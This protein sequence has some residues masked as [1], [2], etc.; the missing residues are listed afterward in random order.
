MLENFLWV[1]KYRPHTI[2]DVILPESLKNTFQKFVDQ[3]QIPN[4]I[5]SG[6]SGIGKTTI[7][8]AL[9]DE[10]GADYIIINASM[11]SGIDTLRTEILNYVTSLSLTGERKFVILDEA[12]YLNPNSTQPA[13]RNFIETYSK[14]AGFIF[15]CNYKNKL[16]PALHSRCAVIDFKISKQ[17]MGKLAVQFMKRVEHI[18]NTENIEFEKPAV[19]KVIEKFFPDWRRVLMELQRYSASGRIDSGIFSSIENVDINGVI[20]SCKDKKFDDVRA[21]V[22]SNSDLDAQTIFRAMYDQS[23][24]YFTKRS[25]PMLITM[26]ND[27]AYKSAFVADQ[28]INLIAFFIDVMMNLEFV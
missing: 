1:E 23:G 6:G 18:L 8:R 16:I 11:N 19:A 28:E 12:D 3:K 13:L 17:D 26:I 21:W 10:I 4:L 27:F 7:A 24:T 9:L 14:N 25:I 20:K 5:L 2:K 22:H 15:T